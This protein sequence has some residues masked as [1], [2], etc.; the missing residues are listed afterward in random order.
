MNN[1]A[2]SEPLVV[3]HQSKEVHFGAAENASNSVDVL[4]PQLELGA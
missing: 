2:L 1:S 3:L 4:A